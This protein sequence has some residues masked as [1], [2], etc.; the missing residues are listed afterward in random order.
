M[1]WGIM[2]GEV[3]ISGNSLNIPATAVKGDNQ[4]KKKLLDI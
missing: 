4:K 3:E 2:I 1:K